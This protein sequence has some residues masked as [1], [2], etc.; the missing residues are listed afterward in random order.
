MAVPFKEF[1]WR[2]R[3]RGW[4]LANRWLY[5]QRRQAFR[6]KGSLVIPSESLEGLYP[7]GTLAEQEAERLRQAY[8]LDWPDERINMQENLHVV[9]LLERALAEHSA[10]LPAELSVLDVGAKDWHYLPGLQRFLGRVGATEV[11]SLQLTGIELDPYYRYDDGYTRYD[12][13]QAYMRECPACRYLV[14]DVRTHEGTYDL[15][16]VLFPF[17]REREVLDWG[18]PGGYFDIDGLLRHVRGLVKPGSL[19]VVSAF[20]SEGPWAEPTFRRLGWTALDQGEWRSPF[21][22]ASPI[23]W[24]VF[25]A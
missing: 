21:V 9:G 4:D 15:A 25:R 23:L 16:L 3:F 14:G 18:L 20:R 2:L 5:V 19:L 7:E 24:W 11:R 8:G 22:K 6:P 13:A 10:E 1:L 17:W 12:Y